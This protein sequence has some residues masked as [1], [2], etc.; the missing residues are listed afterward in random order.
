MT[1]A[2]TIQAKGEP[3]AIGYKVSADQR[4]SYKISP[5]PGQLM[6]AKSIGGQITALA[7]MLES[8]A[9]ED[10]PANKWR[11]VLLGIAT[12]ADGSVT[13]DL[14]IAPQADKIAEAA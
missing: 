1:E 14:M 2:A 11:V 6:T 4:L 9:Q 12:A 7:E 10:E 5:Q 8:I 3:V 13:F